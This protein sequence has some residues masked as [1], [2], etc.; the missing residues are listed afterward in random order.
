MPPRRELQGCQL[1]DLFACGEGGQRC[2]SISARPATL[3][4][5][6]RL[7]ILGKQHIAVVVDVGRIQTNGAQL[8]TNAI[9]MLVQGTTRGWRRET[10]K[11][12]PHESIQR[13]WDAEV[14]H[15]GL[16]EAVLQRGEAHGIT[17]KH[18]QSLLLVRN[19]VRLYLALTLWNVR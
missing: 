2:L 13:H 7:P 8:R 11:G 18:E 12:G 16:H 4:A 6:H 19:D 3:F 14:C 1:L 10:V 17:V 9:D 15:Q 5:G